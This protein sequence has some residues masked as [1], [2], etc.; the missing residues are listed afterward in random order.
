MTIELD[1]IAYSILEKYDTGEK[2]FKEV[3]PMAF[4]MPDGTQG[5]MDINLAIQILLE[6]EL[7][8]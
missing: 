8:K 6:L 7:I 5:Y 3:S 4:T 1:V 2:I